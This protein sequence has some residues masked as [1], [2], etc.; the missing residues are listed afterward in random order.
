MDNG[1]EIDRPSIITGHL[2]PD[3]DNVYDLGDI[4]DFPF[5]PTAPVEWEIVAEEA[6]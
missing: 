2:L 1:S 6:I 5:P 3:T 4:P